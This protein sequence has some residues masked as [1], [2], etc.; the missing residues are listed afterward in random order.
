MVHYFD[1][2]D[3]RARSQ[4]QACNKD[5]DGILGCLPGK[6]GYGVANSAAGIA[7][8]LMATNSD[9]LEGSTYVMG[10]VV[11]DLTGGAFGNPALAAN[12][13][14]SRWPADDF[15]NSYNPNDPRKVNMDFDPQYKA[16]ETIVSLEINHN[17][18]DYRITS[19][20]GYSTSTVDS[21]EDYE[22]AVASEDWSMQM[23]ALADLAETPALPAAFAPALEEAGAGALIP[24]ITDI[25]T[26][27]PGVG[28]WA[29]NPNV[30]ALRDGVPLLTPDGDTLIVNNS[31]SADQSKTSPE[32]WSQEF[33]VATQFDGDWNFLLGAFYLDY[34]TETHYVVRNSGLSLPGL[35]L[36]IE[37]TVF[38]APS[39]EPGSAQSQDDPY[40]LGYDNDTRKYELETWALFGEAY[41]DLTDQMTL[42][43]GIRYSDETKEAKQ[44]TIYVTFA[45]LPPVDENN[46]YFHPE[47]D[48]QETTGA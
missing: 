42:T 4:K 22:K 14:H 38:P 3:K 9:I 34:E 18:G 29:G 19:L 36:P 33:R 16:D 39:G 12:I 37:P 10:V 15:A 11:P 30:A 20:T 43:A 25:A 35:I 5:A 31:Y 45:D 47:Y 26:G 24:F 41:W 48:S 8:A 32:Q 40:M 1:E 7:G 6:L 17:I 13:P 28:L 46:G 23:N 21:Q 27:I 2:D 44:R